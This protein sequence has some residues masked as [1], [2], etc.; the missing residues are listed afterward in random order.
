[1]PQSNR[2]LMTLVFSDATIPSLI[3]TLR[4]CGTSPSA[5]GDLTRWLGDD[6][7][8][9]VIDD[10][11]SFEVDLDLDAYQRHWRPLKEGLGVEPTAAVELSWETADRQIIDALA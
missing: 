4:R 11:T 2:R 3:A 8:V 1:M 10:V 5:A 9:H 7:C 6:V